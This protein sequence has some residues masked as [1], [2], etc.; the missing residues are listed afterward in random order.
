MLTL[1]DTLL[2]ENTA[3][4]SG[5]GVM[6]VEADDGDLIVTCEGA[7]GVA[8]G[9][10]GNL[11]V[12]NE[13]GGAVDVSEGVFEAIDCDFGDPVA[14]TDNEPLDIANDDT[15][16]GEDVSMTCDPDGCTLN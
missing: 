11:V 4:E 16:Y 12:D 1:Q 13:D 5:A 9:F 2:L 15:E 14:G 8:A 10:H 7:P 6:M 3:A